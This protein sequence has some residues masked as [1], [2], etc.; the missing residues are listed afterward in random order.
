LLI[1][2]AFKDYFPPTKGGVEQHINDIVHSLPDLQ[3]SVLTS[4]RSKQLVTD[5]DGDVEVIRAPEYLRPASTPIT[6]YWV[7]VL[8][9]TKAELLHFHMPNPFGELAFLAS[10]SRGPMIATYHGDIIGRKAAMRFF[11]PFQRKFLKKAK[12]IIVSS[13]TMGRNSAALSGFQDKIKVIP[14]GLDLSYWGPRPAKA[15]AL[16][17]QYPGAPLVLFLGRL[18]YFKGLDVLIDAMGQVD[19]TCLIVGDGPKRD[20]LVAQAKSAPEGRVVFT[21]KIPEEDRAAYYHAADV[22]VLPS[23]ASAESFGISML[24]A[25]ACGTPVVCTELGTGTSWLNQ[26][27]Q[28]GLVVSPGNPQALALALN[29]LLADGELRVRMGKA[30]LERVQR[31]FTKDKM[32]SSLA[33]LYS[34]FVG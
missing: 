3:F 29:T 5:K 16:R 8:K 19:A 17:A 23:T 34:S 27:G 6:P 33:E 30:A 18:A 11:R 22:F 24:E 12:A 4:S 13:E 25:M 21:N 31:V 9:D 28:T 15:D 26:D 14:F 32:L 10:K 7:K 1:L 20:E 2:H